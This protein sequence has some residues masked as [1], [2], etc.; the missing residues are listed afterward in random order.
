MLI[1]FGLRRRVLKD[2]P[3]PKLRGSLPYMAP[4]HF[5]AEA[6]GPWTDVYALGVTLYRPATGRLPR[7]GV[8]GEAA[9]IPRE[10][11]WDPVPP[12]P[13]SLHP[14]LGPDLNRVLF[15]GRPQAAHPKTTR[16]PKM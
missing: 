6:L 7:R 8:L 11:A 16:R 3:A 13:S 12:A 5:G 4:E 15:I 10:A 1:D 2:P 9:G 14:S